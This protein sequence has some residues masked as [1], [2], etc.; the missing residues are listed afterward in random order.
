MPAA[1][2]T[3]C[4]SVEL[5]HPALMRAV[6][7]AGFDTPRL[8]PCSAQ[9]LHSDAGSGACVPRALQLVEIKL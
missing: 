4:P 6:G 1:V 3:D 9:G 2:S 5:C 7:T 8:P